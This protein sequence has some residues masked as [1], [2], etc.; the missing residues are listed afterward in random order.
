L[1]YEAEIVVPEVTRGRLDGLRLLGSDFVEAQNMLLGV[2]DWFGLRTSQ[3]D[4]EALTVRLA[5]ALFGESLAIQDAR[6]PLHQ[7]HGAK[8]YSIS[9]LE[10]EEPGT[11]R[12]KTSSSA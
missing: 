6:Y 4:E 10:R 12:K 3:D 11:F 1:V 8:G 2:G 5:H 7:H 9:T